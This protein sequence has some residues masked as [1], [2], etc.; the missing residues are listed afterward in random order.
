MTYSPIW[1]CQGLVFYR[2]KTGVWTLGEIIAV[3][4]EGK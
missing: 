1:T 3:Q 2:Y 4:K